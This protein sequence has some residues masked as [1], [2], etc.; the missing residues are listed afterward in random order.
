MDLRAKLDRLKA[1]KKSPLAPAGSGGGSPS[2]ASV[3]APVRWT[4]PPDGASLDGKAEAQQRLIASLK[5]KVFRAS[6]LLSGAPPDGG[7]AV[8][9]PPD[10]AGA[11]AV[12]DR[13]P[14][15]ERIDTPTGPLL[16]IT[17]RLPLQGD[18]DD[19]GP[20]SFPFRDDLTTL[21]GADLAMVARDPDVANL[22]L[23]D[24]A[25][26]DTETTGLAGGVGTYAFLVGV[27]FVEGD[28]FR[29][30]QYMMEDYDREGAVMAAVA[31][32]LAGRRALVTYNGKRFDVPLLR[33]RMYF[34]GVR[35]G[36]LDLPDIDLLYPARRVWRQAL[37]DCSLGTMESRVLKMPP[38]TS[39]LP[40][41]F[42]PRVFFD[43]VRGARRGRMVP[44]L[45]HNAQDIVSLAS[46]LGLLGR[47]VRNPA[48]ADPGHPLALLGLA[49]LMEGAGQIDAALECMER[50]LLTTR[51]NRHIFAI[52][53]RV[54]RLYKQSGRATDAADIWSEHVGRPTAYNIDAFVELAKHLEHR[55]KDLERAARVAGE[56]L[57][58]CRSQ[59]ALLAETRRAAEARP[60]ERH[61]A[62]LEKRVARLHGKML[63]GKKRP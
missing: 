22:R 50:A 61:V 49:R 28:H 33:T 41:A 37:T 3:E 44:V 18:L 1:L 58:F 8:P 21:C 14:G 16:R 57:A 34:N 2:P 63:R 42:I 51:D 38:R 56:A 36:A 62:D 13:L 23:E 4:P 11:D 52:S 27:G 5:G 20:F 47:M 30:D 17:R 26:L 29:V 32:S 15:A 7:A 12:I 55:V 10:G 53:Q 45:D 54:A 24:L 31:D 6:Q 25:F 46:L 19:A 39:D 40:G 48:Q 43:Y 35:T 9:S 60:L 59:A